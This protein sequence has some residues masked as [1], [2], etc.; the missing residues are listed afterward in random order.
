MGQRILGNM[1]VCTG[2]SLPEPGALLHLDGARSMDWQYPMS[3]TYARG[4]SGGI[5]NGDVGSLEIWLG[6]V[7]RIIGE[8]GRC[9]VGT[10]MGQSEWEILVKDNI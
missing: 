5:K 4:W 6:S 7:E 2:L 10:E 1:W 3:N 9:W 8:D